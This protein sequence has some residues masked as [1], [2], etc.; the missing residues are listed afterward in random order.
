[1]SSPNERDTADYIDLHAAAELPASM[2]SG[3][4]ADIRG[5]SHPGLVRTTNEDHFLT[6]RFGRSFVALETNLPAGLS[7]ERF[8][9]TGYGMV[10]ADGVGGEAAGEVASS[11]AISVGLNLALNAPKWNLRMTRA[12]VLENM[13]KWQRRFAQI[14]TILT[15]RAQADPALVG[16]S[17]TLT[18]ACSVGTDLVLYHVGDSRGYLLRH[19]RLHRLT[20]DHTVAQELADAG[21]LDPEQVETHRQRH[22]LTRTVGGSGGDVEVEVQHVHLEDGDRVLVCTDGL[23][24]MVPDDAIATILNATLT[25]ADACAAL[26]DRALRA[27]GRDNVT[28]AL[29]RYTIPAPSLQ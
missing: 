6:L 21:L 12:E 26:L 18:V 19:G 9:E 28:I 20:H 27:G 10:V 4:H 3:V 17:T 25:S 5:V 23:T 7:P 29:A 14:D 22:V 1:M 11:L 24:D 16:M 15:D 8:A 13:E 2:T